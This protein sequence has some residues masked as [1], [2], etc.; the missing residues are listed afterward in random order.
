MLEVGTDNFD[1]E[2]LSATGKVF[3]DYYSEDCEPCKAL[4]PFI[5]EMEKK[6][7]DKMKFVAFDTSISRKLAISQR[8]MGLPAM[9][10]YENGKKIMELVKN[11]CTIEAIENMI[12]ITI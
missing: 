1:S 7:G 4:K 8:I 11:D 2:V 10:I 3:V 9:T 12:E 5:H 6:Y